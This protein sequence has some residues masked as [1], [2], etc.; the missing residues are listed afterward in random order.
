MSKS[1]KELAVEIAKSY[2]EASANLQQANGASKPIIKAD[3]VL[4][5]IKDFHA[6][7]KKLD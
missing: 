6:E 1:D 4:E 2:I 3:N 5:L 7:L